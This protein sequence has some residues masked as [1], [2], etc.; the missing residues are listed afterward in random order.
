MKTVK[1]TIEQYVQGT[2]TGDVSLLKDVFHSDAIMSGNLFD[3]QM[4]VDTPNKFFSDIE[5][6]TALDAYKYEIKT[7][8]E[9]GKIANVQLLEYNLKGADFENWFQLQE[10]DGKWL[11]ISKLFTT[12]EE[13]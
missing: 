6:E 13:K 11:I 8:Y 2:R 1:E 9:V 5:G 4:I 10:V 12:L 3:I 7:C